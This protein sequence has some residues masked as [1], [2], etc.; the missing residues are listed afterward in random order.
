MDNYLMVPVI[1]NNSKCVH[2]FNVDFE[3]VPNPVSASKHLK[4]KIKQKKNL[5][6]FCYFF[7]KNYRDII[8]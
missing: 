8:M 7:K 1:Y 2:K 4:K 6:V 3:F 5:G